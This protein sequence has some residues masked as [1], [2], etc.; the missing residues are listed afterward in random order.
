LSFIFDKIVDFYVP[1]QQLAIQTCYSLNDL[2]T[3]ER[4]INGLLQLANRFE[5]KKMLIIS[6][7]EETIISEK[8]L[9][10]EVIPIC[11]WLL[12]C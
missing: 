3:S 4:E 11:K 2:E 1:E 7:D 9:E 6:K 5:I 12:S 8:G 10:I